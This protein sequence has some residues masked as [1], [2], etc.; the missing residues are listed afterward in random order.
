MSFPNL[1]KAY[2]EGLGS[3]RLAAVVAAMVAVPVVLL[4]QKYLGLAPD[5]T[6]PLVLGVLA[7]AVL[8]VLSQWHI[9]KATGGQTTTAYRLT[10]GS[11]QAI[12]RLAKDGT[13]VDTIARA[14]VK[15]MQ[16]AEPPGAGAAAAELGAVA[17][18]P[19]VP[20]SP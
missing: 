11:A 3:K 13:L 16:D 18:V 9:D 6:M 12:E 19:P 20:P 2:V 1:F 7:P 5:T 8:F 15:S 10:L 4:G 14:V 17:A